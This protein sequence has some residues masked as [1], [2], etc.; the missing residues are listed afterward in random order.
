MNTQLKRIISKARVITAKIRKSTIDFPMLVKNDCFIPA[1]NDTRWG[2][3]YKMLGGILEAEK[4]GVLN[5]IQS[6]G[7]GKCFT[8]SELRCLQEVYQL[9]GYIHK[10]T[11]NL[12]GDNA[13]PGMLIPALKWVEES[14]KEEK[15][16]MAD[17]LIG[18][19]Q[20]RFD[21]EDWKG[22]KLIQLATLLDQRYGLQWIDVI[23]NQTELKELLL[24]AIK[25]LVGEKKKS[26]DDIVP[27]GRVD[28]IPLCEASPTTKKRRLDTFWN[29]PSPVSQPIT[30]VTSYDVPDPGFQIEAYRHDLQAS[31][32]SYNL[33]IN[34][35]Q[36]FTTRG[37]KDYPTIKLLARIVLCSPSSTS[38]VERLFSICSRLNSSDRARM[39][40]E[41][42]RMITL[43]KAE[44]VSNDEND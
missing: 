41:T 13:S 5:Q 2:S 33:S 36:W 34:P 32:V 12:E 40:P 18:V 22:D 15:S 35:I 26:L 23:Q 38:S 17:F 10:L 9:L 31:D 25:A 1:P 6:V 24:E 7:K 28:S 44:W 42:L 39:T 43:L 20:Q 14:L 37:D 11:V 21:N 8:F 19:L 3:I 30:R 16:D 27:S 29:D 4:K